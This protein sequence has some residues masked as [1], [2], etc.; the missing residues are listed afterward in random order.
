MS[1]APIRLRISYESE[2]FPSSCSVTNGYRELNTAW[3]ELLWAAITVGR[4]CRQYVFKHGLASRY[5]AMF[6][7]SLTR[8]ALEQ[9]GTHA[10]RLRRTSA[11]KTLD[12][13][14]KGA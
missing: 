2:G 11:A 5:E 14:E 6:R 8:M 1:S 4:P 13:T 10:N 9:S 12:P 3:N 7:L